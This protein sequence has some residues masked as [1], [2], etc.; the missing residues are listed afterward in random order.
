MSPKALYARLLRHFGSQGWWSKERGFRPPEWEICL[1]AVLTQNTSW[2]NVEKA[3]EN[4]REGG[5]LSPRDLVETS[6]KRLE[7]MVRPSGYYRQKAERLRILS[8]FVLKF[9]SVRKFLKDV[10][11]EEL[12]GLKG[13]GPETADSILLYAGGRPFFVV[14]MYTRRL[15]QRLGMGDLN[16][17]QA[18]ELASREIPRSGKAYR[19]FHALVV[20]HS[21]KFCRKRPECSGCPLERECLKDFTG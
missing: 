12:L 8:G 2:K 11:R 19:E 7:G 14:D 6:R 20:E 3:L 5:C 21:K 15:F 9:G 13:I 1:G 4:L 16:Y 10:S 18:Q 17:Q